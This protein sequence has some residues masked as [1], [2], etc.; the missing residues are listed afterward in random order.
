MTVSL[1]KIL[2]TVKTYP[3]PSSKYDEL[4]C[5]AGVTESGDFIRLYPI[6]Y[7]DLPYSQQYQKYQWIEVEAEK[8]RGRDN[9]KESYRPR[10]GIKLLGEPITPKVG[11]WSERAYFVLKQKS[12]SMEE[13]WEKQEIDNTSLGVFKPKEVIGLEIQPDDPNWKPRFIAEL[14]QQ[15]LWEDRNVTKEPPRK[16]PWK[17]YYRFSCDDPNCNSNHRMHIEDWEVGALYWN[18]VDKGSSSEEAAQKVKEK[19]FEEICA[20]DKNTH[21]FVGTVL[22]H[23]TWIVIGTFWP[24]IISSQPTLFNIEW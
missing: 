6:N 11:D 18:C 9:R 17:F 8:H 24:K 3:I 5:T 4:V 13:L 7:R 20:P 1:L 10:E 23:R 16:V 22:G 19:F 15:R 21:F 2:I 14:K 12:K